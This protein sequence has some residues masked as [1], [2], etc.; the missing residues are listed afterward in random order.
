MKFHDTHTH[1]HFSPDARMTMEQSVRQAVQCGLAGI[2]ITDHLDLEP[3]AG[4]QG[5]FRF[6]PAQQQRE[7]DRLAALYPGLK[8][9]KGVEAG[10]QPHALAATREFLAPYTF[11]CVIAS[12]HF[13]DGVDPY[14]GA[15]YENKTCAQ[16]YGRALEVMYA[17]ALEFRDFDVLGHFDYIARYAPYPDRDLTYRA[18]ADR[19]D[20]LLRFLAEEGKALEINTNTYRTRNGYTPGLDTCILRRFRELG[21][22][23]VTLGS[24]AHDPFRLRENFEQ[25]ARIIRECGF[26]Y[27]AHYRN[28]RPVFT[29]IG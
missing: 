22:E 10:L 17:T 8:I 20:P 28:R 12:Q 29:P 18:F 27:L 4:K 3:P 25:Y 9:Y 2:A 15:Y 21:G 5:C 6:D 11:D 1:S 14:Y 16:A 7:I 23:A 19:L 26:R 13:V 24:D